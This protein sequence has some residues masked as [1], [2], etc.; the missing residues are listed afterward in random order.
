[1]TLHTWKQVR[2]CAK[3]DR[4]RARFVNSLTAT[5]V[6]FICRECGG[7]I[8][9]RGEPSWRGHGADVVCLHCGDQRSPC[10]RRTGNRQNCMLPLGHSQNHSVVCDVCGGRGL[11]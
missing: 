10:M 5:S 7:G 4:R 1:M 2:R 9:V 11:S 3:C 6:P 8:P